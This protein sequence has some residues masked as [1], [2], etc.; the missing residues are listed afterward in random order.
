LTFIWWT[1]EFLV[2]IMIVI[3]HVTTWH[4]PKFYATRMAKIS[5]WCHII[6]GSF[7]IFGLWFGTV[8]NM[9]IVIIIGAIAGFC[10]HLPTVF[11]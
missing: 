9:K 6:G 10:L 8:L 3:Y 2:T 7:A 5:L 11:Y 1:I 4:H